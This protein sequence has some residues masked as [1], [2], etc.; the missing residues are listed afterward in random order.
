M[1]K[2]NVLMLPFDIQRSKLLKVVITNSKCGSTC[3]SMVFM[4]IARNTCCTKKGMKKKHNA[5]ALT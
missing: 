4:T 5:R 3:H 2:A 1:M